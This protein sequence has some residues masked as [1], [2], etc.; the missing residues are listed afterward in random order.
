[1]QPLTHF[2]SSLYFT[3]MWHKKQHFIAF[4]TVHPKTRIQTHPSEFKNVQPKC[5]FI[6]SK[7]LLCLIERPV[8]AQD[9]HSEQSEAYRPPQ[10]R[11]IQVL[12]FKIIRIT[13]F[14]THICNT[15]KPHFGHM[16]LKSLQG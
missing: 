6:A 12:N 7:T 3:C 2:K 1:M 4:K 10:Q 14:L 16:F 11:T 15:I 8:S 9:K 5:Y 13:Q